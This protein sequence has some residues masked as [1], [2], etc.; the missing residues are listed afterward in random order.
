MLAT[1]ARVFKSYSSPVTRS[2]ILPPASLTNSAPAAVS[3]AFR[4]H[5]KYAVSLPAATHAS[6][7][8][9]LPSIRTLRTGR[10]VSAFIPFNIASALSAVAP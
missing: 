8:A 3:H 2:V 5:S 10:S 6:M 7:I 9:A 4:S 1:I